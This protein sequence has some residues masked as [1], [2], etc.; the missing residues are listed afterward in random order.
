HIQGN[1]ELPE[2]VASVADHGGVGIG[3]YRT[4]FLFL[5]RNSLPT[6]EEHY[7]SYRFVAE[8]AFPHEV[9]IRTLDVGGDKMDLPGEFEKETNPALG[10]R[11]IRYCLQKRDVFKTQLRGIIRAAAHGNIKILIPMISS[12]TE[13]L[14]TKKIIEDVKNELRSEREA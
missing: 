13:L 9:V 2:E 12:L 6:E 11:A 5:N 10:L 1:I 3:L 14:E 7:R 4:E 8:K